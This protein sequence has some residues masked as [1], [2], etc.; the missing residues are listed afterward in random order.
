MKILLIYPVDRE[1]MPPSM[2]PIGLAYIAA[3]LIHEGH[4]I[5]V[6]DL[7]GERQDGWLKLKHILLQE[8][9]DM[10]GISS[11]IT[12]YK[13]V[14]EL[15]TFIKSYVPDKPLVMGGPG[16]TS[17]PYLYLKN[18]STDIVCVGEGEETVKELTTLLKNNKPF[19][20]CAGIV[21][22]KSDGKY[23]T[24]PQRAPIAN[25]DYIPLPAWEKFDAMPVYVEN[26]L[27][28]SGRKK[29]MSILSTRG[30]PGKCIYCM[31]NLGERLRM[32][33]AENISKEIQFLIKEY[34]VEHIHFVDDTLV[35]SVKRV[36]D[37]CDMFKNKFK[38]ITWSANVRADFVNRDI[39]QRM[40]DAQCIFLAYGIES[41]SPDV[42]K[43][44]KKGISLQQAQNALLWTR[45]AGISLRAYFII[46][47]PCETEKT[48]QETV[49]FCKKNLVGGEFFF[50][51]PFPGTELYY[52]ALKKKFITNE[53]VYMEHVGEVRDFLVNLTDMSNEEL[54]ILK[55][56]SEAEIQKYLFKYNVPLPKSIR[57]DPRQTVSSLPEF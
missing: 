34:N 10:I 53:E 17:F 6:V 12:Q 16:P 43:Y 5:T 19:E 42:L 28:R 25:I 38:D 57:K 48:V 33:S 39:L 22:R 37:I 18:C 44:I 51:T 49:D 2:P 40:A 50:A 26:F 4:D 21:F 45:E 7:N 54:F 36:A 13:R 1:F 32:R 3:V 29:G 47:M 14:K 31:R 15:G 52:Y 11:I 20:S 56:K 46:G 8:H 9:F 24:T 35:T 27:F 41:G 23:I 55:E 30:C